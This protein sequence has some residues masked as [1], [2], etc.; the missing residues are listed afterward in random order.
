MKALSLLGSTGSIGTNV[1]AVVR[2]FPEQFRIVGLAAG[3]NV[4][5][6][7]EQVL[8][9]QPECISVAEPALVSPLAQRL[10]PSYHS[11]IVCGTE[12]NCAV[13]S[14]ASAHMVVSAVVGAIGLLPALTAIRAGKDVGLANK[15]T[16][17][18][19]GRLVMRSAQQ[20]KVQLLPIDSEHSAIFQALE[21]GRKQDV[22]RI[23][24]TAS[25]GPF[26][27]WSKDD[28]ATAA[29]AQ[30]LAHPNWSMG[31]KISID[32]ATLMNKG[33]EVIEARWLFD[34]EPEQIEV[35]VHPQ[36]I[37]HSLVE[38]QDGSVVAQLGIPDMRI[39]IAYALS[40]PKRLEL[41]L[42]RLD[43]AQCGGL[44]FEQPDHERFPA[45]RMAY[46]A[47]AMG[48]VKPA[49][50]NAANEVAVEAFLNG[51]IGFTRIAEV[52]DR[53]LQET[54]QG[55]E[56]DLDAILAADQAARAMVTRALQA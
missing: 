42:S 11:R 10:P 20:H 48:G 5:L 33:L 19:A 44:A 2:Q 27:T 55:D 39:P 12:G 54:A 43:L 16:L 37:V 45:L 18:M 26:R 15:E 13:A 4:A 46:D 9:F 23:I 40:Y 29:P 25:G 32:S 41:G 35:V 1:L 56:L 3:R 53:A 30:A 17:V 7:A 34:V 6:L 28:L 50:L 36:S 38:Y 51:R 24:L 21:A 52:V 14:L 49:V 47:L 8:E 31:R 22:A